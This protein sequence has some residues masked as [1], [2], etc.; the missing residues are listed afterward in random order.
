MATLKLSAIGDD[1]PVKV[2]HELP[3]SVHR[4]LVTYAEVLA[5]Q[6]GRPINDPT[7]LIAPM[8]ARFMATDRAFATARRAREHSKMKDG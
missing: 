6:S 8:L 2:T 3:A 1:K 4:D 5:G 7:K